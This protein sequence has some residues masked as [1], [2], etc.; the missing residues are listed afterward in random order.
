MV[1]ASSNNFLL[2][3]QDIQNP[4]LSIIFGKMQVIKQYSRFSRFLLLRQD[5]NRLALRK[6]YVSKVC[7]FSSLKNKCNKQRIV[8]L[9]VGKPVFRGLRTTQVQTSLR[10]RAV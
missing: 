6:Y 9:D 5:Y 4:D 3:L 7:H 1:V 8:G 10:I 2:I